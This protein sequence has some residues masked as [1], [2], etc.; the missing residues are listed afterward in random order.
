MQAVGRKLTLVWVG[1]VLAG[2]QK[3]PQS[4][5]NVG[6]SRP[7]PKNFGCFGG[8]IDYLRRGSC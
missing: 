7:I 6:V 3:P 4:P 5:C 1:I 2:V 8:G